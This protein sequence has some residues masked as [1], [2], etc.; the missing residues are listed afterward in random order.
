MRVR[1]LESLGFK[2]G[3]G[4]FL[5]LDTR[6][7]YLSLIAGVLDVIAHVPNPGIGIA[8]SFGPGVALELL[9]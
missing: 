9:K 1:I 3:G 8:R 6:F 4:E 7:A 2:A 5:H